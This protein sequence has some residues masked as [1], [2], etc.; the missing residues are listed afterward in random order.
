[1]LTDEAKM[2]D[3]QTAVLGSIIGGGLGSGLMT[4]VAGHFSQ[5]VLALL[6]S[7]LT[8]D[9]E[10]PRQAAAKKVEAVMRLADVTTASVEAVYTLA[11]GRVHGDKKGRAQRLLASCQERPCALWTRRNPRDDGVWPRADKGM[12]CAGQ[13]GSGSS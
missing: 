9:A 11:I 4:L 2:T 10:V 13:N 12:Q 1:L 3:I 7:Q 8:F 6:N 5:R